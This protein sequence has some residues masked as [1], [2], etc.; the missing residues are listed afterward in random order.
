MKL[1]DADCS[2][3]G[4]GLIGLPS[5]GATAGASAEDN[6]AVV[7]EAASSAAAGAAP[8]SDVAS[9]G[10]AS[11]VA[12]STK[13]RPQRP[14]SAAASSSS[15][16]PSSGTAES[17]AGTGAAEGS[18]ATGAAEESAAAGAAEDSATGAAEDVAQPSTMSA[19]GGRGFEEFGVNAQ[20]LPALA[21]LGFVEPTEVQRLAVPRVLAGEDTVLLGETGTGKTLAYTVPVLH[22]M[23]EDRAAAA[24]QPFKAFV[25]T[26]SG[27]F[28]SALE[29]MGVHRQPRSVLLHENVERSHFEPPR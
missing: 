16:G 14:Q 13:E 12:S 21:R 6:A 11:G 7:E 17:P 3:S 19:G 29:W 9:G 15:V 25:R 8:G 27:Q 20:L 28:S 1:D 22:A 2:S 23:L 18:A 5:S 26:A 4:G 24:Q 10:G